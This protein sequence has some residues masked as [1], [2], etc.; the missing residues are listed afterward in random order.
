MLNIFIEEK[1]II[2]LNFELKSGFR[3]IL[4]CFQQVNLTWARD[5]IGK[6]ATSQ[7][8]TSKKHVT[9]MSCKLEAAIWPRDT[10]QQIPCFDR[11]QL[12]VAWMSNKP[13]TLFWQASIDR[14][15]DVQ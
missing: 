10:G 6:R 1:V 4:P 14:S 11:R 8:S 2:R 12:I 7:R 5:P 3:T 13:D 9:S 15:M